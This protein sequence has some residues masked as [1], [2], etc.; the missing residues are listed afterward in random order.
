MT[1][2]FVA[3]SITIKN[4]D[5]LIVERL[6]KIVNSRFRVVVGDANGVDSSVQRV[7]LELGCEQATVFSSSEKPRNNLGSWP[8]RVVS[9]SHA[10]GTRAFF[11]AKDLKM[12]EEADYGLMVWDTK[13]TGTLSNVIELLKRKKCSVVFVNKSKRF[14]II[15][16]PEHLDGLIDCMSPA[17]LEKADEKIKL[18]EKISQL[19]NEQIQLI[20]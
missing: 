8:V 10:A 16:S 13:S 15:K 6:K 20:M 11:T 7:L 9:T 17:S 1:T 3:G 18:R 19:K 14:F 12:A 5:T 2:V 4:L